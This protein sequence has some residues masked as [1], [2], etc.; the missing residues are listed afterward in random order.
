MAG[1]NASPPSRN[2]YQLALLETD[3]TKI[4]TRVG[5]ARSAIFDRLHL[6]ALGPSN[7]E[8]R[9]FAGV[10]PILVHLGKETLEE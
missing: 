3:A 9:L 8:V 10:P 6:M 4:I 2:L 1:G 5:E 7:E